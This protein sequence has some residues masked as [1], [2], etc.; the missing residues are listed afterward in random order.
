M[1][2]LAIIIGL[3]GGLFFAQAGFADEGVHDDLWEYTNIKSLISDPGVSFYWYGYNIVFDNRDM[4]GGLFGTSYLGAGEPGHFIFSSTGD[5]S[6]YDVLWT[7]N[8]P[9]IIN[10]FRLITSPDEGSNFRGVSRFTLYG[11]YDATWNLLYDSYGTQDD[12]KDLTKTINAKAT[13]MFWAEFESNY[14][15]PR[16]IELDG[17]NQPI[18][19]PVS[20]CLFL[21]GG[22]LLGIRMFCSKRK[23]TRYKA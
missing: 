11:Y 16:I 22:S 2:R 14:G 12:L 19:E 21:L 17:F 23:T 8:S 18:P 15:S 6:N 10:K 7:L 13:D 9:V 1:L 5:D 20:S 3:V 4:F